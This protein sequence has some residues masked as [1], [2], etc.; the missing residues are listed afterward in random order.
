MD[1]S[2]YF[3]SDG[4]YQDHSCISLNDRFE[5][6][7]IEFQNVEIC[8]Y[9]IDIMNGRFTLYIQNL[10]LIPLE[11]RYVSPKRSVFNFCHNFPRIQA[12]FGLWILAW[13]P[14]QVRICFL[15]ANNTWLYDKIIKHVLVLYSFPCW[16]SQDLYF[17]Y[18]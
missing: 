6:F 1:R 13:L 14:I 10:N 7:D 17:F 3:R 15:N 2:I 4:V 8:S 16:T 5:V 11:I 18:S 12:P 9:L